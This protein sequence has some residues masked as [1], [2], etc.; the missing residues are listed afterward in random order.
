MRDY[1]GLTKDSSQNDGMT[2]FDSK[3]TLR[4]SWQK[5]QFSWVEVW[6]GKKFEINFKFLPPFVGK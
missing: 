2:W 6:C 4:Y 3:D 1:E 5:V